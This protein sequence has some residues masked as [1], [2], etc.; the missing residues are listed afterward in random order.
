MQGTEHRRAIA[1]LKRE[2]ASLKREV[3]ELR[4]N[5]GNTLKAP[6]PVPEKARLRI[7]GLKTHRIAKL[8]IFLPR[9]TVSY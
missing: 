7:D 2:I 5:R 9:T 6:I 3:I 1:A 4:K 8:G